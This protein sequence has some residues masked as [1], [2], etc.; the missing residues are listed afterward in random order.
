YSGY[1]GLSLNNLVFND[2]ALAPA[3]VYNAVVAVLIFTVGI[4]IAGKSF[5]VKNILKVPVI[6]AL[7]IGLMLNFS[8]I[9][10][11]MFSGGYIV[12]TVPYLML[13]YVGYNLRN[14]KK[15]EIDIISEGV[16]AR[17]F[18]GLAAGTL[19]I[20]VFKPGILASRVIMFSSAL[21]TALS[22]IVISK[23]YNLDTGLSGGMITVS[24]VCFMVVMPFIVKF[25]YYIV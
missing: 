5:S 19:F 1:L 13:I 10:P 7:F 9:K 20:L 14:I 18:G 15:K 6:Y 23:R 21:P 4:V 25:I 3:A 24:T 11:V 16:L 2:A 17:I 22:T 12:N 8:G